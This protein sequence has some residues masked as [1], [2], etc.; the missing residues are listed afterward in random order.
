MSNTIFRKIQEIGKMTVCRIRTIFSCVSVN[1]LEVHLVQFLERGTD[2]K[3]LKMT[4]MTDNLK[5]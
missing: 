4:A 3:I 1:V 5:I 2:Y